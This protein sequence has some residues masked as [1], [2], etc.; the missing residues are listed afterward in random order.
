[1]GVLLALAGACGGT[2]QTPP[3]AAEGTKM[4]KNDTPEVGV[5]RVEAVLHTR[6][7][8]EGESLAVRLL[9]TIGPDG[10]WSLAETLQEPI[11]GGV[12]LTPVVHHRPGDMV[13]Q[14]VIPLDEKI[15][16][17]LEPG[18]QRIEVRGRDSTF[19]ASVRVGAGGNRLPPDTHV[20]YQVVTSG[21]RSNEFVVFESFPGDGFV[22]SIQ[23][24]ETGPDGPGPWQELPGCVREGTRLRG[25]LPVDP[26]SDVV[27]IEARAISGQGDVDPEPAALTLPKAP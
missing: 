1:M 20:A 8:A 9:G 19:V 17:P 24:R 7:L 21:L 14:M 13:I 25:R 27:S 18:V 23:F 11:P 15:W 3:A 2:K 6:V 22:E 12:R 26:T 10:S 16:V 4:N 5:A